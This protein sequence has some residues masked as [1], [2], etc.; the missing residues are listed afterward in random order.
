VTANH[1]KAIAILANVVFSVLVG[2]IC[3]F[4]VS[5]FGASVLGSLSVG[6]G[7]F[8]LVC[9]LGLVIIGM[10]EFAGPQSTPTAHSPQRGPTPT[11]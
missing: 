1:K 5:A 9:G 3:S 4:A 8:G 7:A 2:T 10:F 11:T 6:G